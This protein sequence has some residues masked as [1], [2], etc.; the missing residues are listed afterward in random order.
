MGEKNP[1]IS[2]EFSLPT[3][4]TVLPER[5]QFTWRTGDFDK[6]SASCAGGEFLSRVILYKI[7][8]KG[9]Y[10]QTRW[11]LNPKS[12]YCDPLE[13]KLKVTCCPKREVISSSESGLQG[14]QGFN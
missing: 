1:G 14:S 6:C 4:V 9:R 13:I 11:E 2:Y 3:S 12:L 5:A 8:T 10:P 7:G